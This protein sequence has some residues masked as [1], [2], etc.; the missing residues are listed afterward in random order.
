MLAEASGGRK[1]AGGE[2]CHGGPAAGYLP[3]LA[4]ADL[5]VN[6]LAEVLK[7]QDLDQTGALLKSLDEHL[8]KPE[9]GLDPNAVVA[10]LEAIKPPKE[11]PKW[12][13]WL[14]E[15]RSRLSKED[16]P[17]EKSKPPTG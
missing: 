14:Q 16:K 10:Q 4:Q 2:R 11:R 17:A 15:R 12:S 8:V 5:A 7:K 3:D 1:D 13:Q 9:N 6:L